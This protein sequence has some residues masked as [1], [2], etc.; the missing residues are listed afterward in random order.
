MMY[1]NK[2]VKNEKY[3]PLTG[4]KIKINGISYPVSENFKKMV[5]KRRIEESKKMGTR[6][7]Q[8]KF[9]DLV[10]RGKIKL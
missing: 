8:T 4:G 6:I 3:Y 2:K 1:K 5:E 9:T 7:S 10:A